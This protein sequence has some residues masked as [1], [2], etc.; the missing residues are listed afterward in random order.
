[1]AGP[2]VVAGVIAP[3]TYDALVRLAPVG[4]LADEAHAEG[5]QYGAHRAL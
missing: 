5:R 4:P 3:V 2:L 1:V